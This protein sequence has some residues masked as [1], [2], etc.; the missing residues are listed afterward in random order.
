[1][2]L[3]NCMLDT[4][5]FL[6]ARAGKLCLILKSKST[7]RNSHVY[8]RFTWKGILTTGI[9]LD[10]REHALLMGKS[11]RFPSTKLSWGRNVKR[12]EVYGEC[13][14]LFCPSFSFSYAPLSLSLRFAPLSTLFDTWVT[15]VFDCFKNCRYSGG[16]TGSFPPGP[17]QP[18]P[19]GFKD[20]DFGS[21]LD[22]DD[23]VDDDLMET[24]TVPDSPKSTASN[25]NDTYVSY[26]RTGSATTLSDHRS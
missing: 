2:I 16:G 14:F 10:L 22:D 17:G 26:P 21:D 7:M 18:L 13:H 11:W 6:Q 5:V 9:D 1:M 19:P 12:W 8:P 25:G 20:L 15:H 24:T 23:D 4:I 3:I